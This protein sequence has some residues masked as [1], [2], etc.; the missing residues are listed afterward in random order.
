MYI[1]S[2]I[3]PVFN[4]EE[5]IRACIESVMTQNYTGRIECILVDDC[6]T[7]NS[8]K[9]A[10]SVISEYQGNVVFTILRHEF[11]KGLS[12]ARNTGIKAATGDYIFFLDSD[13]YIPSDCLKKLTEPLQNGMFDVV[14][15]DFRHVT[16]TKVLPLSTMNLHIDDG[17]VLY[18]TDIIKTYRRGWNMMAQNKLYQTA[19]IKENNLSFKEGLIHEDEL[20]S[21]EVACL[22][23]SLCAVNHI[24]YYYRQREGSIV[25]HSNREKRTENLSVVVKEMKLFV[26]ERGLYSNY[27]HRRINGTFFIIVNSFVGSI[28]QYV[29]TY[30]FLRPVIRPSFWNWLKVSMK[31]PKWIFIDSHFVLPSWIAPYWLY[32][33]VSKPYMIYQKFW[34]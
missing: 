21:F 27:I 7:D 18:G 8:I 5:Y 3:I 4:V 14:V 16:D 25:S 20:W 32:F 19:F 12:F 26:D 23:K 29:N 31:D 30:L 2:I 11:N 9:I 34:K 1:I 28:K 17:L 6:G 24:T 13:D 15:G 10:E 22:A 33:T